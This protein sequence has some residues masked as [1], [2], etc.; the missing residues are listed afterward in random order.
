MENSGE[1]AI[2]LFA[3]WT[4]PLLAV[5]L[6]CWLFFD[7]KIT[8]SKS[9]I[10][11]FPYSTAGEIDPETLTAEILQAIG[12]RDAVPVVTAE[13]DF[14]AVLY[15]RPG[16]QDKDLELLHLRGTFV[17]RVPQKEGM[18]KLVYQFGY[19]EKEMSVLLRHQIS[20]EILVDGRRIQHPHP[21]GGDAL[22]DLFTAVRDFPADQYRTLTDYGKENAD[23]YSLQLGS[24]ILSAESLSYGSGGAPRN[25]E[26]Q[27]GIPFLIT[28]MEWGE[29]RDA[30]RDVDDPH[31]Y[32]SF[33]GENGVNVFY[34]PGNKHHGANQEIV[35]FK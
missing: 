16:R 25:D 14:S 17:I 11:P 21:N 34:H 9:V 12:H 15:N 4:V 27:D 19:S 5:G 33:G 32:V 13:V 6:V 31:R 30:S 8:L 7:Q 20:D 10:V 2:R 29:V 35:F 3:R 22:A 28:N 24:H 26:R 23:L 18:T 1:S